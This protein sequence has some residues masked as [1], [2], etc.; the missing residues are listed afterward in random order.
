MLTALVGAAGLLLL[1]AG[2]AKV[3]DPDRTAGALAAMGLPVGP[4]LVR[5]G[6]AGEAVVGAVVLVVGGRLPAA[7]VGVSFAAFAAFVAVALRSDRPIGTCGCFGRADTPPRLLHVAVDL[8]LA[9]AGTAGAVVGVAPVLEASL[10]EVAAV[11]A[12][13]AGAYVVFTRTPTRA[14]TG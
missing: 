9:A 6:A 11:V 8:V 2:G 14:S 10:P 12:L 4:T 7:L 13:A 1:G 3:V 5:L